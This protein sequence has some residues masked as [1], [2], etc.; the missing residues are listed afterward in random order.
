MLLSIIG[1]LQT[2]RRTL[3]RKHTD[4]EKEKR[5]TRSRKQRVRILCKCLYFYISCTYI[6]NMKGG[7]GT[8]QKRK[9]IS[10]KTSR[11]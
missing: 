3:N 6:R 5:L 1:S 7:E 9:W 2:Y 11:L 8:L 4:E 10:G